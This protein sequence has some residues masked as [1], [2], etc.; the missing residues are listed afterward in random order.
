MTNGDKRLARETLDQLVAALDPNELNRLIDV[1]META[2]ERLLRSPPQPTTTREFNA[3]LGSFYRDLLA[4]A[5]LS[6]QVLP[7]SEA[8]ADAVEVLNHCY[9]SAG[10]GYP[11]ALV[12]VVQDRTQS[13]EFVLQSVAASVKERERAGYSRWKLCVC[14]EPLSWSAKCAIVEV[15]SQSQESISGQRLFPGPPDR[16]TANLEEM[17]LAHISAVHSTQFCGSHPLFDRIP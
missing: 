14:L 13:M 9:G 8:F 17:V 16:F 11:D 4:Q 7:L 12:D 1:P 10:S 6:K 2:A 5:S 15:I 3:T